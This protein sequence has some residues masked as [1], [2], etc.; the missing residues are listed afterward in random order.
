MSFGRK[1]V[2]IKWFLKMYYTFI[3]YEL[4]W[5]LFIFR[6]VLIRRVLRATTQTIRNNDSSR[7]CVPRDKR[8]TNVENVKAN[9]ISLC[10]PCTINGHRTLQPCTIQCLVQLLGLFPDPYFSCQTISGRIQSESK[11]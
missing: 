10:D 7:T 9:N 4:R 6:S 2:Y 11:I 5:E 1:V 8:V 3:K